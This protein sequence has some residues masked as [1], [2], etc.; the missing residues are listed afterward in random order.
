ML[1][2]RDDA[3]VSTPPRLTNPLSAEQSL[4][5]PSL[6]PGLLAALTRNASRG[7][8]AVALFEVGSVFLGA[9][10]TVEPPGVQGPPT[11]AQRAAL[12]AALPAQPRHAAVAA[13]RRQLGA[14]GRGAGR[15]GARP[16]ARAAPRA[17]QHGP[18]HPG[19][20]AELLLDGRR[21]GVAGELHPRVV[22]ALGLPARTGAGE[23]NLDVVVAAAAQRGPVRAPVVSH[24]PPSSVD[25]ALVVRSDVAAA[26]VGAALRAGAG[27]LL[28]DVRLFDVYTGPQ[29]EQ[30]SR[31]LAFGLRFRAPDRT[32]TDLDV[33]A[34]RDAAVAEAGSR[35]GAVLR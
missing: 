26:D 23:V 10:T 28:E 8:A 9:G 21:V 24:Y 29:V 13:Q 22:A 5:R 25:V 3:A 35:F 1:R 18:F 27:E 34:A 14:A 2:N 31:S 6:L 15:A 11:P 33:L 4:L 30:G 12:D 32:L 19:R 20:C 17:V 16:R 7:T